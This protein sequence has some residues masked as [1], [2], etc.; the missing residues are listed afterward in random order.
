M[1]DMRCG[2][3][4]TEKECA[5]GQVGH[6]CGGGV[7]LGGYEMREPPEAEDFAHGRDT[8][9]AKIQGHKFHKVF[10]AL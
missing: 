1:E 3:E 5:V 2:E 4:R 6:H 10:H 7:R 9:S 8:I